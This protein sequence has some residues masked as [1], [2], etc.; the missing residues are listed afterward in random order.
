M[1]VMDCRVP[2]ASSG[3]AAALLAMTARRKFA[4][5]PHQ[6]LPTQAFCRRP[7][8]ALTSPHNFKG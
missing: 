8:N 5:D 7:Q 6:P 4:Y 3:Q 2:S 1:Q